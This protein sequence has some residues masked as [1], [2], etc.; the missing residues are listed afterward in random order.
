M[1]QKMSPKGGPN[2]AQNGPE[3]GQN[4]SKGGTKHGPEWTWNESKWRPKQT[5]N[6]LEQGQKCVRNGCQNRFTVNPKWVPATSRMGPE[7]NPQWRQWLD[8][9]VPQQDPKCTRHEPQ[10]SPNAPKT[11]AK[12]CPELAP[13]LIPKKAFLEHWEVQHVVFPCCRQQTKM[14]P[15]N[16]NGRPEIVVLAKRRRWLVL[17]KKFQWVAGLRQ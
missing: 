10:Q 16:Q 15:G 6:G 12:T 8:L 3:M 1:C 2:Q 4:E 5:R 7:T 11:D 14:W 9:N 13:K 17:S